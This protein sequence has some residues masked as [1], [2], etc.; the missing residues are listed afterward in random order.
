[1][2]KTAAVYGAGEKIGYW[3]LEKLFLIRNSFPEYDIDRIIFYRKTDEHIKETISKLKR[4]SEKNSV[5]IDNLKGYSDMEAFLK[6][7]VNYIIISVPIDKLEERFYDTISN[8]SNLEVIVQEKPVTHNLKNAK[9]MIEEAKRRGITF[10]VNLPIANISYLLKDKSSDLGFD[11]NALLENAEMIK[12]FW[13]ALDNNTDIL[14][15]LGLHPLSIIQ[16][17][18][19]KDFKIETKKKDEKNQEIT[20]SKSGFT[21]HINLGYTKS[22]E[23]CGREWYV[24]SNR[25]NYFFSYEAR[26]GL[27]LFKYKPI[28][29][30]KQSFRHY[31]LPD[32]SLITILKSLDKRPV[33]SG[34][35]ALAYLDLL[36]KILNKESLYINK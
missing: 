8:F 34:E 18:T 31:E 9:K 14:L 26:Q 23:E 25:E 21:F 17:E 20:L 5:S 11:Y 4:F 22:R 10:G 6:E 12:C 16:A 2:K 24:Y 32:L 36:N 35:K 29:E 1:M 28:E 13:Y 3:H 27:T 33:V 30:L 19:I 15:N 7:D